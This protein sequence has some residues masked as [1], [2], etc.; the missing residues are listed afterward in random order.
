MEIVLLCLLPRDGAIVYGIFFCNSVLLFDKYQLS[1]L[2]RQ[3]NNSNIFIS[4]IFT[5]GEK[6]FT[7]MS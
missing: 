3:K 4:V 1:T 7:S 6:G 5:K 2:S